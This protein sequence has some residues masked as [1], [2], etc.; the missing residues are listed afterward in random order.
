M[1]LTSN[2][3]VCLPAVG[4]NQ[5]FFADGQILQEQFPNFL[6]ADAVFALPLTI[7]EKNEYYS[8]T[9]HLADTGRHRRRARLILLHLDFFSVPE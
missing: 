9:R 3:N 5:P 4:F 2:A 6:A 8:I 7:H 1:R